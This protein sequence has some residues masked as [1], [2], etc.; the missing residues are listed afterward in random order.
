MQD[1]FV[2]WMIWLSA[3]GTPQQQFLN[4]PA[5]D[6]QIAALEATISHA[7]PDEVRQLYRFANGQKNHRSV[8]LAKGQFMLPFFGQ[9]HFLST[10][11]AARD[12]QGWK[13][14]RDDS[15]AEFADDFNGVITVRKGDPVLREYWHPGCRLRSMGAAII[16]ASTCRPRPAVVSA[17]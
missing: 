17:R 4:A 7:L 9:Y 5:S 8:T 14:I 6:A 15:G 11:D 13:H 16:M 1:V 2:A 3:I 10:E 12:Y